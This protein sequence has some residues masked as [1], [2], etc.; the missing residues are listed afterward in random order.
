MPLPMDIGGA[1]QPAVRMDGFSGVHD[2]SSL[3][4]NPASSPGSTPNGDNIFSGIN[5]HDLSPSLGGAAS[6]L[7]VSTAFGASADTMGRAESSAE[8]F[9]AWGRQDHDM[10]SDAT[11]LERDIEALGRDIEALDPLPLY[12]V[13]TGMT[14]NMV[15]STASSVAACHNTNAGR[16]KVNIVYCTAISDLSVGCQK[17]LPALS[18]HGTKEKVTKC[19]NLS[20][21]FFDIKQIFNEQNQF[22]RFCTV[23]RGEYIC[24]DCGQSKRAVDGVPHWQSCP[25]KSKKQKE[26]KVAEDDSSEAVFGAPLTAV[27]NHQLNDITGA[28]KDNDSVTTDMLDA[29]DQ[30][31][32]VTGASAVILSSSTKASESSAKPNA[33]P[34]AAKRSIRGGAVVLD[35]DNAKRPRKNY[36]PPD[37]ADKKRDQ[38]LSMYQGRQSAMKEKD[39]RDAAVMDADTEVPIDANA[40]ASTSNISGNASNS[41]DSVAVQDSTSAALDSSG[42][43]IMDT[44]VQKLGL[45][46]INITRLANYDSITPI[47]NVAPMS[48]DV[49]AAFALANKSVTH[50]YK[51]SNSTELIAC[52]HSPRPYFAGYNSSIDVRKPYRAQDPLVCYVIESRKNTDGQFLI[53]YSNG[54][55]H[56]TFATKSEA[57]AEMY[58]N[59]GKY[60]AIIEKPINPDQGDLSLIMQYHR[61][62][63][64]PG[65]PV[66]KYFYPNGKPKSSQGKQPTGNTESGNT[67]SDFFVSERC[68]R[69]ANCVNDPGHRGRC[70][71]RKAFD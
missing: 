10:T 2:A 17:E 4:G 1:D 61:E 38:Y 22:L 27:H 3:S 54:K 16:Q 65:T 67:E 36:L 62:Q 45:H 24:R 30:G 18:G 47:Q 55:H 41:T 64:K 58:T 52:Y 49:A 7:P 34:N 60:T 50:L 29:L 11:S 23:S 69:K 39:Q 32:S 44:L 26:T 35:S 8:V 33:K 42:D 5:I 70:T 57:Q 20:C 9:A 56:Q 19:A 14:P 63:A 12:N 66:F 51:P 53:P 28:P 25:N 6:S 48:P 68:S 40:P 15:H 46:G 21:L 13:C 71:I 43:L 31:P 37:D 59:P